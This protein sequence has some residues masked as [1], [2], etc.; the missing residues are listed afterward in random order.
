M[1]AFLLANTARALAP[2]N[3]TTGAVSP[4]LKSEE[5]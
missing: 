1:Q 2:A 4:E 3:E 5:P